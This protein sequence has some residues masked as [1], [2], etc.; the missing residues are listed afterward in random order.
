MCMCV[1]LCRYM[2]ITCTQK[3]NGVRI[4]HLSNPLELELQ[5]AVSCCVSVEN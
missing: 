2:C 1:I 4:G 5:I 3:A